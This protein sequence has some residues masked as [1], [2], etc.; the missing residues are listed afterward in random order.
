MIRKHGVAATAIAL[1]LIIVF[2]VFFLNMLVK[3]G[4]VAA[5]E[6]MFKSKV[7]IEKVDIQ[8]L[9][10]QILIENLTVADKNH[11][12]KNLWQA[13][14]IEIKYIFTPMLKRKFIFDNI[15]VINLA[16]GTDRKISGF[17]PPGKVQKIEK[18]Q[19]DKNAPTDKMKDAIDNKAKTDVQKMPVSKSNELGDKLKNIDYKSYIKKENLESYKLIK[20][21]EQKL[22][23]K[24]DKT[25]S[26]MKNINIDATTK[27]LES[28]IG[29]IKG[30]KVNS[31]SD[32]PAAQAKLQELGKM[33]TEVE[34]LKKDLE[35]EK[36]DAQDF[37]D[38][39][40]G[41][42][43]DIEKAKE[44]DVQNV[45][46][47]FNVKILNASSIEKSLIGPIWYDRITKIMD[48]LNL[49]NKYIPKSQKK[50]KKEKIIEKKRI[51]G[52]DIVFVSSAYPTFWIKK[53]VISTEKADASQYLVKGEID[54]ITTEQA[55]IGRPITFNLYAEKSGMGM[56]MKGDINH[57]D[58]IND[59]ITMST[60][61]MPASTAGLDK[62]D[63]GNI[64]LKNAN[65][66]TS[67]E[68]KN[69]EKIISI[70]G[71]ILLS[72]VQFDKQDSSDVVYQAVS[73]IDKMKIG[74]HVVQKNTGLS[75]SFDSDIAD[76]IKSSLNR[77]YGKKVSDAKDKISKEIGSQIKD[78]SKG[79]LKDVDGDKGDIQK[80]LSADNGKVNGT[81][82]DI[83]NAES[84]INKQIESQG[85]NSAVKKL[86]NLFNK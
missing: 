42:S 53:V 72:G 26:D 70:N 19:E 50:G 44:K 43:N 52:R 30:V 81:Q 48:L 80:Q 47:N 27:N 79:L 16:I 2:N 29:D 35:T 86:Q 13:Q 82:N 17:L 54:D 12:F 66:D 32:I 85:K 73:G 67:A 36:N 51:H 22:K 55:V 18:Q 7:E 69:M 77:I 57:I 11:E 78:E 39:S 56:I 63:Y 14:K 23:D 75:M 31:A 71:N 49:I 60:T 9:K 21:S 25:S 1:A 84:A 10:S 20:D 40:K 6:N 46:G 64:K 61:K 37:Y 68:I 41:L 65:M 76:R 58:E 34:S 59:T 3:M 15:N 83:T 45:L 28:E 4:L 62:V 5:G 24:K 8:V 74:F 33:K 38:Y